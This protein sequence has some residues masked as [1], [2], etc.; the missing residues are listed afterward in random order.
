MIHVYGHGSLPESRSQFF[1]DMELC[2][3][4]LRTYIDNPTKC[5][6]DPKMPPGH[7]VQS[8]P[9]RTIPATIWDIMKQ[10]SSGVAFMHDHNHVHRDIKPENST[11]NTQFGLIDLVL[12]SPQKS[13]WKIAD[14]GFV[15]QVSS[16]LRNRPSSY[17]RGTDG[18]RAPELRIGKPVYSTK[19]DIWALGCVL[20]ELAFGQPAFQGDW[21]SCDY[22]RSNTRLE[23]PATKDLRWHDSDKLSLSTMLE[24][25][26]AI[27]EF[28]RPSA[29]EMVNLIESIIKDLEMSPDE[30]SL[31]YQLP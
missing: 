25:A 20:H 28:F 16:K 1:I 3:F 10:I 31:P 11:S 8:V 23:F 21:E 18:Y 6:S 14:F 24:R 5:V 7:R 26:L 2:S 19:T 22:G 9:S 15:A 4:N 27:K 17:V 29:E 12:F 30:G 13:L